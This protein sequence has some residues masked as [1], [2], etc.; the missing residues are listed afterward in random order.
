[1]GGRV[2]FR[3]RRGDKGG[4]VCGG[5]VD[6][7]FSYTVIEWNSGKGFGEGVGGILVRLNVLHRNLSF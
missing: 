5:H 4:E 3:G 7:E 6:L 2:F 1:M